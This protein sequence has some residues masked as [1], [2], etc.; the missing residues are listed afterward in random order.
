MN[1]NLGKAI[2]GNDITSLF[3][4]NSLQNELGLLKFQFPLNQHNCDVPI[5][6]QGKIIFSEIL[7]FA[8]S[9]HSDWLFK[10]LSQSECLNKCKLQFDSYLSF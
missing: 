9:N 7:R 1:N 6:Y 8:H 4:S 5:C 10:I 3:K 2:F